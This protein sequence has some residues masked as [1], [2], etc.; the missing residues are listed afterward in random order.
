MSPCVTTPLLSLHTIHDCRHAGKQPGVTQALGL[1][2]MR[3]PDTYEAHVFTCTANSRRPSAVRRESLEHCNRSMNRPFTCSDTDV[4]DASITHRVDFGFPSLQDRFRHL[5]SVYL[6]ILVV[7]HAT[8]SRRLWLATA[9]DSTA[10]HIS[11]ASGGDGVGSVS[12]CRS[13]APAM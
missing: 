6:L 13:E 1:C 10:P 11:R 4:L 3:A 9:F 5:R 2:A 8:M 12:A 7:A